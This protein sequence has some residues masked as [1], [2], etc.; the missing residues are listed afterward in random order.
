[1]LRTVFRLTTAPTVE[2][3]FSGD[4]A[5][6]L[7]GRWNSPGDRVIYAA[8]HASLA[9][10]E[11]LVNRIPESK[12]QTYSLYKINL[13]SGHVIDLDDMPEGW[14]SYPHGLATQVVGSS[15]IRSKVSLALTVPSAVVP[16][17]RNLLINPAHKEWSLNLVEGPFS[18]PWDPRLA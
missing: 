9:V 5:A 2:L 4:G 11:I 3:A 16:V 12:V 7:G 1:M 10:L 8:D 15:W 18:F 14:Q 13:D 6:K 17:E